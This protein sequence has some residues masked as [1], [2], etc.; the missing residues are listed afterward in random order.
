MTAVAMPVVRPR[1]AVT[2][3]IP[4]ARLTR[5]EL[6]KMFDT[7]SGFWLMASLL[8]TALL[9]T[10]GVILWAPDSD[11]TYTTFVSAIRFPM[12]V[13]LPLI[14]IL[15]VTSEWSQRS[16]LTTFTLVPH[17]SRVIGAK[18]IS[19]VTVGVVATLLAL[20]IGA[21]G[22]VA[23]TAITG[24]TLVWDA[25]LTDCLSVVLG[26]TL[27]LLTGFMLGVLMRATTA[28]IVA[29]FVYTFLL[30]TVFG[31]AASQDWFR[32]LQPWVDVQF[33]QAPLFNFATPTGD[34]WTQ[35]GFTGLIWLVLPLIVG[36]RFVLRSEVK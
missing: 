31:L 9:A 12:A 7:R 32:N 25:S 14:A 5:I 4:L 24:T 26:S 21:L 10:V 19:S 27:S 17:R 34:Q 2:P 1:R 3:P 16:G 18:A 30:P 23:G 11:L 28:A 22:N 36:L 35:I 8:I 33:A 15:S 29:F 6:R 13:I 20:A